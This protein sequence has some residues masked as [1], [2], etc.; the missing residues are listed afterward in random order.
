MSYNQVYGS[1]STA[2]GVWLPK[3]SYK[4][5][6]EDIFSSNIIETYKNKV[7]QD[8]LRMG[9]ENKLHKMSV[10]DIGSGRHSLA[11]EMLGAKKIDLCDISQSNFNRFRTFK[12]NN[13]T[14]INNFKY[15]ICSSKFKN[16]KKKYDLIY[17]DGVIQHTKNP[18][19]AINNLIN[20]LNYNGIIW[21]YFYNL[22]SPVNIYLDIVKKIISKKRINI[23]DCIKFFSK[24]YNPKELDGIIDDIGC[25]YAYINPSSYYDNIFKKLRLKKIYSKDF[26]PHLFPSLRISTQSCLVAYQRVSNKKLS[27]LDEKPEKFDVLDSNN[28]IDEDIILINTLREKRKNIFSKLKNN[29]K[30]NILECC[31]IFIEKSKKNYLFKPYSEKYNDLSFSFTKVENKLSKKNFSI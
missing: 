11:F 27:L 17:L 3:N 22:G 24:Y 30:K 6:D 19:K 7:L 10:L 31:L 16:I 2:S 12:K 15:D 25:K 29:S 20:K 28:Y 5:P 21:F 13:D 4:S 23:M 1:L 26:Y 9:I 18:K 8:L 14:I